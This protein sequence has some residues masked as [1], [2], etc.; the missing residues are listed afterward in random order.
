MKS[1]FILSILVTAWLMQFSASSQTK[2]PMEIN[3]K[4]AQEYAIK[5]SYSTRTGA[6]DID[7]AKKKRWEYL[8]VGMPQVGG[9]IQYQ[10]M[11]DVPTQLIPDFIS[12]AIYGVLVQEHLIPASQ[13]PT[14]LNQ[15]F[16]MKFG[17]QHN[18]SAGITATQLIFSGQYLLGVKAAK[19]LIDLADN[20]LAKTEQDVKQSVAST[21]YLIL[22][23]EVNKQILDSSM[24]NVTKTLHEVTEMNKNG[25]V[26]E[27]DVD[28]I[29]IMSINLSN[30]ISTISRQIE[31]SNKLLKFQMGLEIN[32]PLKLT[33][34][35][36]NVLA[37]IAME[38]IL[39]KPFDPKSDITFQLINIQEKL[40]ILNVKNERYNMYPSVMGS[41]VYQKK[42]M[43][44]DLDFFGSSSKWYPTSIIGINVDIP[45]FSSWKRRTS[46]ARAKIEL[47]KTRI[48]KK[49][50]EESLLLSYEQAKSTFNN[51]WDKFNKEK[52]NMQLTKR[53][54]DKNLIKFKEGI[55]SSLDLTQTHSQY[56]TAE[57]NYFSA[58]FELLNSKINL[59]KLYNQL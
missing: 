32:T 31:L 43:Q 25:F 29:H 55:S 4:T 46:I 48:N 44:D 47:E 42:D 11:L 34:Q 37:G 10:D 19:L 40:S 56:L 18:L 51:S 53:I 15:S 20:G 22:T 13:M 21:Y 5:N 41:F 33:E 23:L 49:M 9:S 59:D 38:S 30:L 16:P 45:I 6:L 28:Q 54:H 58:L 24:I 8:T 36:D 35:L 14:N 39:K 1:K 2:S 17:T 12:P 52:E 27:S 7:I 50:L 57:S 3:L 26:E